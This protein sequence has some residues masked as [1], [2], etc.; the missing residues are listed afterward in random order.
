MQ[1]A[2]ESGSAVTKSILQCIVGTRSP[3]L[4][5]NLIPN[6]A[7]TCHLELEFREDGK[8][9]F[10]VIGQGSVHLRGYILH[11]NLLMSGNGDNLLDIGWPKKL[12]GN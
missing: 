9:M 10:T 5:C 8:V 6:I 11:P 4:L 7:E 1:A 2:L 12:L 3:V